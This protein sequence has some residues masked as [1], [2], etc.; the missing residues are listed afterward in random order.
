MLHDL[1]LK[2]LLHAFDPPETTSEDNILRDSFEALVW[3]LCQNCKESVC[4]VM[5]FIFGVAKEDI[6]V[7]FIWNPFNSQLAFDCNGDWVA[8]CGDAAVL[9]LYLLVDLIIR[10]LLQDV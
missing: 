8:G 10:Y 6:K 4:D 2:Q 3:D 7:D 9:I 1:I 5:L